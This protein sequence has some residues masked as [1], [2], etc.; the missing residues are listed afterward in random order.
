MLRRMAVMAPVAAMAV[1]LTG[2]V[3]NAYWVGEGNPDRTS[4]GASLCQS[5]EVCLYE[6]NS[7]NAN[8]TNH[9]DQWELSDLSYPDEGR[10][11]WDGT[12]NSLS[13]DGMDNELS[14]IK[15]RGVYCQAHIYQ[16]IGYAG[17]HSY[18]NPGDQDGL[19]ADNP[20][21]DNRASSH[22]WWC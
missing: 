13:S 17:A 12:S 7:Y 22:R 14:S 20:I 3:A 4:S 2:G 18:F 5:G 19:L 15:N 10:K 1:A 16:D 8:N 21:G 6:N 9:V 11:W